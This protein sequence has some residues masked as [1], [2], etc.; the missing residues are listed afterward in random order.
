M[1]RM[2]HSSRIHAIKGFEQFAY[3]V[4]FRLGG[5]LGHD[6]LGLDDDPASSV[7]SN[8]LTQNRQ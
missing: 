3:L 4:M 5:T 1:G 6:T 8:G 2:A 7:E